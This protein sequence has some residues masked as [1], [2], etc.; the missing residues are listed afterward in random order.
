MLFRR[1]LEVRD[2]G[3]DVGAGADRASGNL[4]IFPN[5][6]SGSCQSSIK[7]RGGKLVEMFLAVLG[8]AGVLVPCYVVFG[9]GGRRRARR[10]AT[11]MRRYQF[12]SI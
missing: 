11:G 9:G 1:V 3:G 5:V 6:K 7:C 12:G 2:E 4:R 8:C 10:A